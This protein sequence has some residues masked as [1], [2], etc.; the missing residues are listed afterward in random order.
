MAVQLDSEDD[1]ARAHRAV[2]GALFTQGRNLL[3]CVVASTAVP[4]AFPSQ[5]I[6]LYGAG[7]GRT[8]TH[9]FVDGGVLNNSPI[10]LAIDAGA[11][12]I[13]SL[14]LDPL[15]TVHPLQIDDRGRSYNILEAGVTT[16]TTLLDR[17]IERDMRRTVTWNRFLSQRPEAMLEQRGWG[18]TP[19]AGRETKRIMPLY[20][21]APDE[22]EIGTV[23][24]DGRF[25]RGQ[26]VA[27]VRDVLRRGMLDLR[28]RHVWRAT[29]APTP[30]QTPD[31]RP[32]KTK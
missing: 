19:E 9:R 30:H 15:T 12:H 24:F 29:L 10:H 7:E 18:R 14:E 28:G 22:R 5:P 2:P 3:Q 26:V 8:V 25:D 13:V 1:A 17:A 32:I 31:G 6:R 11:T 21:I 4:S 16:F 20:R 23:E 27:T